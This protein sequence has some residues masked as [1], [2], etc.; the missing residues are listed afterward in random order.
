MNHVSMI[1]KCA[2]VAIFAAPSLFGA[3]SAIERE[4]ALARQIGYAEHYVKEFENE[5]ARQRGGE[6]M[7]WRTKNDALTRVQMLKRDY[8]DDPRVESLYQRTRTALKKSK[9]DYTEVAAEWTAYLHNE[10]NL[11]KVISE[12]GEKEWQ[13]LLAARKGRMIEK[14][15]PAPD[16]EKVSL[17]DIKGTCV[18]LDDVEYPAKQFYGASGEYIYSGKRSAG[19]WFIDLSGRDWLGPYEAV[20]RYR[21]NVDSGMADVQKWTVLA[22]I[23]GIAAENPH[24]GEE[25]VGTFCFG[26]IVKPIALKVP[27]HVVAVHDNDAESSGRFIGEERVAEIKNGWYSVKE[28][29]ADV[30]PDR[31]MEIFMTAIKEKNI[32]LYLECID[33]ECKNGVYG[34][35][36]SERYFWDLHQERFHREYV[37]ATF[38]KPVIKVL[39]GFDKDNDL[40]NFFLDDKDK[41]TLDRIGG[42]RVEEAVVESRAY[43]KNGKQLGTPH[44]HHLRRR[45]GGRWYVVDYQVRF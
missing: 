43:D 22:E 28:I 32:K 15:F 9:G 33:P 13:S 2:A 16:S 38:S 10:E 17:D 23:T 24:G 40:E 1:A 20:K 6:K 26:W 30:T 31:L 35:D 7:V 34:K 29:P 25:A 42:E 21:R 12:V 11:R 44:E 5:V 39:K 45:A 14:P 8:P 3:G 27:G 37:H 4:R 18:V 19:F 41:K 36:E